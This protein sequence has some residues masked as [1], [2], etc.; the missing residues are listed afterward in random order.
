MVSDIFGSN[1]P[2]PTWAQLFGKLINR[3]DLG[4]DETS[5]AME[6]IMDGAVSPSRLA[7]FLMGLAAKGETVEELTGLTEAMLSRAHRIT[8]TGDALDIVGTGGDGLDTLNISTMASLVVV[9]AGHKV[10]KHGN[11]GASSSSGAADVIEAL[12]VRLDLP[13]ERVAEVADE[14]G[15]TFCFAQMFHPS[16]RHAA[17]TRRDLGVRTAFNVLGPLTNPARVGFQA[18]GVSDPRMAPLMAGVL[19][20]RG[21]QA[22][23]FRGNDGRDKMTTSGPTRVWD[24]RN[25]LVTESS[26]EPREFDL[27]IAPVDALRGQGPEYNASVVRSILAGGEGPVRDAV[28]L[29]AAAGMAAADTASDR[30]AAERIYNNLDAARQSID[31]G[32][33]SAVLERWIAATR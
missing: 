16:M 27:D 21:T 5:W 9:G 7:A 22:L 28:V 15:I 17:V 2:V 4:V 20:R 14:V 11:R 19:A 26:V 23:V 10:V 30:P 29:N 1:P 3:E 32:A 8:V 24:V 18:L 31:S 33:A 12:G 13:V 6:N 25:G